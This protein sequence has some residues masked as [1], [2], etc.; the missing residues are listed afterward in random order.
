MR[1]AVRAR[2]QAPIYHRMKSDITDDSR[3]TAIRSYWRDPERVK[4]VKQIVREAALQDLRGKEIAE[5]AGVTLA[6]ACQWAHALG[7]RRMF[8]TAEERAHLMERRKA[9]T[10]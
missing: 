7:F 5:L 8:V 2:T 6:R 10:S 4:V 1:A 9:A 3:A